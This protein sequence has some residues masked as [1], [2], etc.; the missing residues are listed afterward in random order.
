MASVDL[1]TQEGEPDIEEGTTMT[2]PKENLNFNWLKC[3]IAPVQ[4]AICCPIVPAVWC[5]GNALALA[6][7]PL[8][9]ICWCIRCCVNDCDD[10][11]DDED[12]SLPDCCFGWA[13]V[14]GALVCASCMLPTYYKDGE[15]MCAFDVENIPFSNDM[16][17]KEQIM[18]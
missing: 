3:C 7:F 2:E 4:T 13:A 11:D 10:D 6:S 8:L 17:L 16:K 12:A 9:P 15:S 1:K 18:K 5:A 14:A